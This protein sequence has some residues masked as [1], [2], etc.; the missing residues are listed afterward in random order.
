M[1]LASALSGDLGFN[2]MVFLR[3]S[4]TRCLMG[5]S[6]RLFLYVAD[7][8][9]AFCTCVLFPAG[10]AFAPVCCFFVW[11]L[12]GFALHRLRGVLLLRS[13]GICRTSCVSR[14]QYVDH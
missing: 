6:G 9:V 1:A 3:C 12:S 2:G 4:L 11:D 7:I 8:S 10:D 5:L 14:L 13:R